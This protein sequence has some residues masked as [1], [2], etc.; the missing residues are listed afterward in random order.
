MIDP[1]FFRKDI[2]RTVLKELE[3]EIKWSKDAENLLM[4]TVAQESNF[5]YRVQIGGGPALSLYQIEPATFRDVMFRFIPDIRPELKK[6][7]I[8]ITGVDVWCTPDDV[9]IDA[10]TYDDIFATVVARI[11]Y[12][13]VPEAL[14]STI[15][16]YAAYWNK[17]WN[18]NP[19]K[20][21]DEEFIANYKR[22]V[23]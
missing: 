1:E 18:A 13:M 23:L 4:G 17:Y 2:I 20:G 6:K 7:F 10:L 3:P 5:K 9:L 8:T 11:K 21:T 16:G 15:E 12:L 14:P 22:Y 19:D